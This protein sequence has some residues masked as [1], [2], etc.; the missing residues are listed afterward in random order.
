VP[1]VIKIIDRAVYTLILAA[2]LL[3]IFILN[4][5][6]ASAAFYPNRTGY[7]VSYPQCNKS[8]PPDPLY[9]IVGINGGR[10]FKQNPCLKELYKWASTGKLLPAVY[11]NLSFISPTNFQYSLIGPKECSPIDQE[12]QSYNFGYQAAIYAHKYAKSNGVKTTTWWLD[13]EIMNTWSE[14]KNLNRNVIAGAIDYLRAQGLTVGVYSTKYQWNR[15]T[16]GWQIEI[17][18]WVAGAK[19]KGEAP[20]KC[21]PEYSFTGGPVT[22]IQYIQDELDHNYLCT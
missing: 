8:L 14:D 4:S 3:P 7:D 18:V 19:D 9:A 1:K 16:D 2:L 13:I 20:D 6:F 10:P 5:V 12:C 21:K 15:I 22:L 11:M 17:P